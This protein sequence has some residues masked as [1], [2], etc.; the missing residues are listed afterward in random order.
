MKLARCTLIA[1]VAGCGTTPEHHEVDAAVTTCGPGTVQVGDECVAVDAAPVAP[2][3]RYEIRAEP[4]IGADGVSRNRVLVVGTRPD[5]TTATDEV[6]V[7]TDRAG[8]GTYTRPQFTLGPLGGS[9]YFVPCDVALPGCIGPLGLTVALAS[10]PTTVVATTTVQ[11]VDPIEVNPARPCLAGGDMMVMTGNDSILTGMTTI[12]EGVWT[13]APAYAETVTFDVQPP[14]EIDHWHLMFN[15][16]RLCPELFPHVY[17]DAVRAETIDNLQAPDHPA[18][19]ISGLGHTCDTVTGN[20]Q[21]LDYHVDGSHAVTAMTIYFEQ[22][23][24]G[25][26]TTMVSG[27]VHY[28][29]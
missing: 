22:H 15:T 1:L 16:K 7:N 19:Y 26:P 27:C 21:V 25:D 2:A 11:L 24:N 9:T 3:T 8:A 28:Q 14:G 23:C 17:D 18:M 20:F 5:G 13:F 4:Q 29:P 6:V 12:T 10:D